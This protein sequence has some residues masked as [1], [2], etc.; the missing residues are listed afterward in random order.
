[1]RRLK[2]PE[3]IQTTEVVRAD[4]ATIV[5]APAA[6]VDIPLCAYLLV[7]R[8]IRALNLTVLDFLPKLLPR[9]PL[10]RRPFAEASDRRR[11]ERGLSQ[12]VCVT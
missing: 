11:L 12:A 9:L 3:G 8:C 7:F 6:I 1:M 2:L 5:Q 10:G 4:E